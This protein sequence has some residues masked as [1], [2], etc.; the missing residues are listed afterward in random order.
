MNV[1]HLNSGLFFG[2]GLE[3]IIVDLMTLNGKFELSL[4]S[5]QSMKPGTS[6]ST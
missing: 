1:L 2:G 6:K 4:H 3:R 5:K